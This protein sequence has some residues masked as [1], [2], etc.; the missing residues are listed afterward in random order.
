[1]DG[2][3][4]F[5]IMG[6]IWYLVQNK[7]V[8]SGVLVLFGIWGFL[9]ANNYLFDFIGNIT[10]SYFFHRVFFDEFQSLMIFAALFIALYNGERGKPM[11]RFF[12]IYYPLHVFII[13][14]VNCLFAA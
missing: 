1:M 3:V 4:Y 12:Y 10:G 8:C 6:V 13:S 5:V 11:K 9:G 7:Y 14:A 2:S